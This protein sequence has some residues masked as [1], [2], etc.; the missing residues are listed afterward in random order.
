MFHRFR[1]S[2]GAGICLLL[3]LSVSSAY[4]ASVAG[5]TAGPHMYNKSTLDPYPAI[6]MDQCDWVTTALTNAGYTETNGWYFTYNEGEDLRSKVEIKVYD[7]FVVNAPDVNTR[8]GLYKGKDRVSNT[9]CGG[10]VLYL[11]YNPTGSDPTSIHWVQAYR[12][13]LTEGGSYTIHLDNPTAGT[14]WY[15]VGGAAGNN[16]FLDRPYDVCSTCGCRPPT[17]CNTD[18]EFQVFIAVD[19][20]REEGGKMRHDVT[21]YDGLWWGYEYVCV[22]I[23]LPP[24]VWGGLA[25][26]GVLVARRARRAMRGRRL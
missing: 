12:Q 23:P 2:F 14:P 9:D 3:L 1:R 21:V 10:A 6:W 19:T 4:G 26:M 16:W 7:A 15:D 8:G 20:T 17:S 5:W 11:E 13:R 22:P 25:I 18:V 24:A